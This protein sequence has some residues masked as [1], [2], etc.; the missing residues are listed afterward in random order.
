MGPGG[1]LPGLGPWVLPPYCDPGGL[2]PGLGPG[3]LLPYCGP[4]GFPPGLGPRGLLPGLGAWGAPTWVRVWRAPAWVGGLRGSCLLGDST[5]A[6]NEVVGPSVPFLCSVPRG[7]PPS[8]CPVT[9]WCPVHRLCQGWPLPQVAS[10][11]HLRNV[12]KTT[13]KQATVVWRF[14]ATERLQQCCPVAV[15]LG[16]AWTW[17][18][19]GPTPSGSAGGMCG[20][21]LFQPWGKNFFCFIG[22]GVGP[23]IRMRSMQGGGPVG[24]GEPQALPGRLRAELLN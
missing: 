6:R 20:G 1:L 24:E 14:R 21:L 9:G 13:Q 23:G 7:R 2:P 8:A 22:A 3:G 16:A 17:L 5:Q 15:S 12:K 19:L 4:G 10:L 11:F 18:N